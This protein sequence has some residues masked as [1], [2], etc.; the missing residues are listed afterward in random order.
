MDEIAIKYD[1]ISPRR[2]EINDRIQLLAASITIFLGYWETL[3]FFKGILFL[4]PVTGYAIALINILFVRFY[5]RLIKKYGY[6]FEVLILRINGI[7]MLTTGIGYHLTGSKYIQ[8]AYYF[9][10]IW[11]LFILPFFILRL[12]KKRILR[13]TPSKIIVTKLLRETEMF[14]NDIDFID[15]QGNLLTIGKKEKRRKRKYF[16]EQDEKKLSQITDFITITKIL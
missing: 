6:R 11:F 9:I 15:L 3:S 14:W 4:L 16:L 1:K 10:T 5:K 12:R 13:F 7:I 2:Q 8:F